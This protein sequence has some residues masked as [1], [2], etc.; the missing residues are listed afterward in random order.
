[1]L[2]AGPLLLIATSVAGAGRIAEEARQ[3]QGHTVRLRIWGSEPQQVQDAPIVVKRVWALGAGLHLNAVTRNGSGA[4]HIKVAQPRR[5]SS[6]AGV[7]IVGDAKY[8]QVSG[9]TVPRVPRAVALEMLL[10][11]R[12]ALQNSSPPRSVRVAPAR[13]ARTL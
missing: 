13:R 10:G 1:M 9:A 12:D 4:L 3:F 8:V 11:S 2:A 5:S 7:F 6:R